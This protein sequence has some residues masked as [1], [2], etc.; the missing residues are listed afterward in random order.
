[1]GHASMELLS[2]VGEG[3]CYYGF[4]AMSGVP[5]VVKG[6]DPNIFEPQSIT[7]IAKTVAGYESFDP[8]KY[9]ALARDKVGR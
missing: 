4:R 9:Y 1:M 2:I 3:I 5:I 8:A 6:G 7:H